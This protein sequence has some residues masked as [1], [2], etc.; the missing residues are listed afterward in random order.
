[1]KHSRSIIPLLVLAL[2][3][4]GC[5]SES[6]VT[7]T[8]ATPPTAQVAEK[9]SEP[10]L[11]AGTFKTKKGSL[12]R[13]RNVKLVNT[14][15]GLVSSPLLVTG[16][17]RLWYFE[18][19]FPIRLLNESGRIIVS[20]QAQADDNWMTEEW[21]PFTAELI[22]PTQPSGSRGTL[23][24]MDDNPSGLSENADEVEIPVTF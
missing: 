23:L 12:D 4:V 24:L 5:A 22:F 19:V 20:G 11:P 3:G 17:A 16:E 2:L 10:A 21:V 7:V 1:M 8:P 14:A 9:P 13:L 15:N 6:A 18:G